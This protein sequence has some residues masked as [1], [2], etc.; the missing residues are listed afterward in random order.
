[1]RQYGQTDRYRHVTDG[2][3]SRL[4][5]LQAA[6]LRTRL[7]TSISGTSAAPRSPRPTPRRW[8]SGPVR[9]L[10]LLPERRH[11]FHLFVV[12]APDR[13]ALAAHLERHEIGTLVHYPTP[14]TAMRRIARSATARSR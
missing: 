13:D 5:E 3:N 10:A 12:E 8:P 9:P 14:F 11:V 7:P 2:V 6:I 4:D 1:M